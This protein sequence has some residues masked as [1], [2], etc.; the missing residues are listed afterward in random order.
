MSPHFRSCL[1]CF[2]S[3]CWHFV[4]HP[5]PVRILYR[6]TAI[7]VQDIGGLPLRVVMVES[8]DRNARP[9]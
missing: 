5:V 8:G 6:D 2:C 7:S 1:Y 3:F 4:L 9:G